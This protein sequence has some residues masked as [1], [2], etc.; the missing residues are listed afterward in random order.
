M[1]GCSFSGKTSTK[2]DSVIRSYN[3]RTHQRNSHNHQSPENNII[4][5]TAMQNLIHSLQ[6]SNSNNLSRNVSI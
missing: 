5:H 6:N 2:S 4:N 3:N 1:G